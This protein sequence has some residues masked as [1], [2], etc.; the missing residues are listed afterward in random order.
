MALLAWR[1]IR[2]AQHH[3]ALCWA[4]RPLTCGR[5]SQA[6]TGRP[7]RCLGV[8]LGQSFAK[9]EDREE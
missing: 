6:F 2:T 9:K 1:F 5:G 3:M 4:R 7:K 8:A